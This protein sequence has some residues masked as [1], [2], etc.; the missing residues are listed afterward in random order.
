MQ[1]DWVSTEAGKDER[2]YEISAQDFR[3]TEIVRKILGQGNCLYRS[4]LFAMRM[5]EDLA[6]ELREAIATWFEN[7][8][9]IVSD[10]ISLSHKEILLVAKNTRDPSKWG[11]DFEI[12]GLK[13]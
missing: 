3:K 10:E 6:K 7:Q 5:K 12:S 9:S 2:N 4:L 1:R 11:G 13:I 8:S